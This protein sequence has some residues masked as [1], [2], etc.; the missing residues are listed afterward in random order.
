MGARAGRSAGTA[1]VLRKESGSEGEATGGQDLAGA[2]V[3]EEG[4]SGQVAGV[5]VV[6]KIEINAERDVHGRVNGLEFVEK[7][8]DG[9]VSKRFTRVFAGSD[10]GPQ[11]GFG[12][13]EPEFRVGGACE[14]VR[15]IETE[16]KGA[17]V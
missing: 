15:G 3:G 12:D 7:A 13:G 11:I 2:R 17:G 10:V 6:V 14:M 5:P 16:F 8:D 9:S 1:D 4:D